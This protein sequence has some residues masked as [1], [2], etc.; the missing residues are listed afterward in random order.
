MSG[1]SSEYR[2]EISARLCGKGSATE[3]VASFAEASAAPGN[4]LPVESRPHN[5]ADDA[6]VRDGFL[7]GV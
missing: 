3:I 4:W 5:S 1:R 6:D 7:A 2:T